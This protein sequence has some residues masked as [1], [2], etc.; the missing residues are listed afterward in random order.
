M[1]RRIRWLATLVALALAIPA[2]AVASGSGT[3]VTVEQW[4]VTVAHGR[5]IR[6]APS[7]TVHVCRSKKL[8]QLLIT[9]RVSGAVKGQAYQEH[10][11]VNGK[12]RDLWHRTWEANDAHVPFGTRNTEFGLPGGKWSWRLTQSGRTLAVTSLTIKKR[13]C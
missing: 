7:S 3:T 5:T 1:S 10:I 2:A 4:I 12:K 6:A 8:I 9:A 11:D 13:D